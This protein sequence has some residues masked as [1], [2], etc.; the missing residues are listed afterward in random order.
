M[1]D[2]MSEIVLT[3]TDRRMHDHIAHEGHPESPD[4]LKWIVDGLRQVQGL[5]EV[6]ATLAT[7][8]QLAR[9]HSSAHI[10]YVDSFRGRAG[11]IDGD[12]LT[13]SGSV[14]AAYLAAGTTCQLT[15]AVC[16]SPYHRALSLVRPPGHHAEP[17]RSMGF[18]LFSNV[19][20]AAAHALATCDIDK[21]MV[22]DWDVHHGNG[23]QRAFYE[24]DDVFFVSVHQS[25][26]YPGTGQFNE[27]GR[28]PGH[29]F[30]QNI[31]LPPGWAMA[32]IQRSSTM[33]FAN[34]PIPIVLTWSWF[35]PALM[36]T[37]MTHWP[38]CR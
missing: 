10:D 3:A 9:I 21:V 18:C 11:Q 17:D 1:K 8:T 32:L 7:R 25:P 36:R 20:V 35:L 33:R 13:S 2:R 16:T 28:G 6:N 26:L 22:I 30:T 19:A 37:E 27:R 34:W 23:T 12:T 38:I 5:N 14:E 15:E 31:P 24:R 4:R 29:G